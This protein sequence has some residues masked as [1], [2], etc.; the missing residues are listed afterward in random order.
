MAK[1]KAAAPAPETFSGRVQHEMMAWLLAMDQAETDAHW[2]AAT[3][4]LIEDCR[5]AF[6]QER[7]SLHVRASL[8]A[9]YEELCG[10]GPTDFVM[11]HSVEHLARLAAGYLDDKYPEAHAKVAAAMAGR[12]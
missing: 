12:A 6:N 8:A 7:D 5:Q 1:R 4:E 10:E 11:T 2:I 3:L 9:R